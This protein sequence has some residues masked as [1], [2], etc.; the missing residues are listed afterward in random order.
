MH[1]LGRHRE[2]GAYAQRAERPGIHPQPRPLRPHDVPGDG[3][4][5]AAVADEDRVLGDEL[6]I[7]YASR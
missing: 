3:D 1:E 6:S 2:P 7:S 5:V 4:D